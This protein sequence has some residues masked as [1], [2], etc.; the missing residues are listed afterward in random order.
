MEVAWIGRGGPRASKDLWVGRLK[1]ESRPSAGRVSLQES[2]GGSRV[3]TVMCF[4]PGNELR[5]E[6]CAPRA[7]V[8]AIGELVRAGGTALVKKHPD[9]WSHLAALHAL[10]KN[11]SVARAHA[12]QIA[13]EAVCEVDGRVV[14][15]RMSVIAGRKEHPGPHVDISSLEAGE[16]GADEIDGLERGVDLGFVS[17]RIG[18]LGDNDG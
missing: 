16:S 1:P 17:E 6:R 7:I 18:R 12:C 11:W 2:A 14:I 15:V 8:H 10:I 9:H 3:H 4:K 5:G 13:S